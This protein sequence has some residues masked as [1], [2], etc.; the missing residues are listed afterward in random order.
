MDKQ[1]YSS[2]AAEISA[3]E[4]RDPYLR[5]A[6]SFADRL[7]RLSWNLCWLFLCRLTL[8]PMHFWRAFLLQAFGA[9]M[10]SNCRFYPGSKV[11][12]PWNFLCADLVA[13][14]DGVE[15]SSSDLLSARMPLSLRVRMYAVG[16]NNYPSKTMTYW[17]WKTGVTSAGNRTEMILGIKMS[18]RIKW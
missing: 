11:W 17:D 7:K 9:E 3:P 15:I 1:V 12:A 16:K 4:Q 6:F 5:P 14:A 2:A 18:L 13:V 8:R 10:V